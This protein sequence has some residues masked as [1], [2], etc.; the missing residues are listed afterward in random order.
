VKGVAAMSSRAHVV[1]TTM[2]ATNL[3]DSY[4]LPLIDWAHIEDGLRGELTQ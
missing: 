4:Q 3:S 2:E 1:G